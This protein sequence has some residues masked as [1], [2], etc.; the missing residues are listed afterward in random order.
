MCILYDKE[1]GTII[2]WSTVIQAWIADEDW[3][4]GKDTFPGYEA[5]ILTPDWSRKT[6][7]LVKAQ[8]GF[9]PHWAD[10]PNWGRKNAFNARSET[11]FEKRTWREA[12]KTRRCV[13]PGTAFCER[14]DGRWIRF[15]PT[16]DD[17]FTFAGL[18]EP[19]NRLVSL[20]TYAMLT[21]EPNAA[22]LDSNDRMPV[23]LAP[24]DVDAW[25]AEG[26]SE[27]D[28]RALMIPCPSE[29]F[30]KEDAGPIRKP[31]ADPEP[32]LF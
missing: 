19:P 10:S 26:T 30:Q 20:P 15:K 6:R 27:Q 24:A 1:T 2:K 12:I 21:T 8:W 4:E 7:R 16:Q 5:P 3:V 28:L 25:L 13:I 23:V 9:T 31:K 29:W 14:A 11:L 32:T 18:Y 17:L 22:V